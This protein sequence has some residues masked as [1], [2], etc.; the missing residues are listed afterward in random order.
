MLFVNALLAEES[1][2]LENM[3][4]YHPS[5]VPRVRA[6]QAPCDHI[7]IFSFGI[8]KIA[9]QN[10]RYVAPVAAIAV[11]VPVVRWLEPLVDRHLRHLAA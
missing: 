6:C 4:R 11:L 9:L 7:P 2:T 5:H 8:I 1:E 10:L 3:K